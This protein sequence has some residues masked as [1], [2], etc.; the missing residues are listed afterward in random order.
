MRLATARPKPSSGALRPD[1]LNA[2]IVRRAKAVRHLTPACEVILRALAL[3][4]ESREAVAVGSKHM[5]PVCSPR[6]AAI[7]AAAISIRVAAHDRDRRFGRVVAVF[8]ARGGNLDVVAD[9]LLKARPTSTSSGTERSCSERIPP[10]RS[11]RGVLDARERDD[12]ALHAEPHAPPSRTAAIL[13]SMSR[14]TFVGGGGGV[15]CP[16]CSR[17]APRAAHRSPG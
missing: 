6:W 16:R 4:D 7:Y 5:T 2:G 9:F 17:R 11:R 1:L 13:P 12:C 15:V 8:H 3:D 14:M 10:G